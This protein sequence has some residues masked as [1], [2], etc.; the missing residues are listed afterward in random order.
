MAVCGR[1]RYEDIPTTCDIA[2]VFDIVCHLEQPPPALSDVTDPDLIDSIV[3]IGYLIGRNY[4]RRSM[5]HQTPTIHRA[6]RT[7]T[8]VALAKGNCPT[9]TSISRVVRPLPLILLAIGEFAICFCVRLVVLA[10]L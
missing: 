7:M 3:G 4:C 9:F 6:S 10:L 1:V 2:W 8:L 5:A